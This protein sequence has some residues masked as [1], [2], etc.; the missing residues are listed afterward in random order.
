VSDETLNE[1]KILD[2]L[3]FLGVPSSLV[4][5]QT[6]DAPKYYNKVYIRRNDGLNLFS[7]IKD[8][9]NKE[10][11]FNSSEAK[12]SGKSASNKNLVNTDIDGDG[13]FD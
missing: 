9:V 4:L 1:S 6:I 11:N 10:V 13:V 5:K 2:R 8:I 7:T 12:S 3:I